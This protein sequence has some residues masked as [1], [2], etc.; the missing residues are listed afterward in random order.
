MGSWFI[1]PDTRRL[2]LSEGQ[3]I[4]VKQ[5]LS[6]GEFRAHLKRSSYLDEAGRRHL[7]LLTHGLSLVVAYLIDWSLDDVVIR[8]VSESD[9]IAVLDNLDPARFTE[10]KTAIEAHETAMDLEREQEKNVTAGAMHSA[11]ISP[12]PSAAAGPSTRS[13][14]L[15]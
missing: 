10:L 2:P 8:G 6:T 9:L 14:I 4:L 7:D 3:W 1:R 5:R 15:T 13:E 11:A 12:L